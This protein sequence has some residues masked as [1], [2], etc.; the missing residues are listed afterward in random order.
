MWH[1]PGVVVETECWLFPLPL[2]WSLRHW[3]QEGWSLWHLEQQP[4]VTSSHYTRQPIPRVSAFL[5]EWKNVK[6]IYLRL[7]D[8]RCVCAPDVSHKGE[9]GDVFRTF[10]GEVGKRSRSTST[11]AP[12]KRYFTRNCVSSSLCVWRS[13]PLDGTQSFS[14]MC[15]QHFLSEERRTVMDAVPG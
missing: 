15:I 1:L 11:F 4:Q 5:R 3:L 8:Q 10:G 14:L 12:K 6:S 7:I 9:S 2:G 13:G